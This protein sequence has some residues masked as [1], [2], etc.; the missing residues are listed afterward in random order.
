M[1]KKTNCFNDYYYYYFIL[2]AYFQ[3]EIHLY[4]LIITVI[5]APAS[6]I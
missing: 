6:H 1:E 4:I 5:M 3:A 2:F